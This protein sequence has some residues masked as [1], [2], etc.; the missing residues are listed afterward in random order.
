YERWLLT[1]LGIP[2]RVPWDPEIGER[3]NSGWLITQEFLHCRRAPGHTCLSALQ[4]RYRLATPENPIND[5]KGC[6]GVMR[7][8]PI[9]LVS[10][11]AFDL[12]CDAAALTH[13]HP[14]G[15]LAAGAFADIIAQV[16]RGASLG[17]A[18]EKTLAR[19]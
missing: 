11:K 14:A 6:G 19:C 18:G 3:S 15:W 8:A 17:I 7:V 4:A 1:Q 12:A 13:G 9:G 5:S 16:I 2:G 10:D